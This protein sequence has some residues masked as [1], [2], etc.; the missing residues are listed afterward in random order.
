MNPK[1]RIPTA[2]EAESIQRKVQLIM[3]M[4][5]HNTDTAMTV[6]LY[7][8]AFRALKDEVRFESIIENFRAVYTQLQRQQD[9]NR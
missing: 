6:L 9:V 5:G 4:I 2:A 3:S 1:D 7:A 8:L